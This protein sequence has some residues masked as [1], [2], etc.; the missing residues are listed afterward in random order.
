M[1]PL[2]GI[3]DKILLIFYV[4]PVPRWPGGQSPCWVN[5]K[6]I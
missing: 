4:S 5:G 3:F 2:S 6:I 1:Q